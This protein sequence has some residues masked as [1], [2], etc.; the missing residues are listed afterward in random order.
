M[1]NKVMIIAEAGVNHNGDLA[2]AYKLIDVAAEAGADYVKFQTFKAENLVTKVAATADYQKKNTNSE[3]E[4]QYDMLKKLEISFEDHYKLRDYALAKRIGFFSTGF[5]LESLDFL[6]TLNMGMWKVPSGEITNLPYLEYI[7]KKKQPVILSTGM[8]DITEVADAVE[9]FIKAGLTLQ[10]LT[11]LHCNTEYPTPFED[12]NLR[13]MPVLGHRFGTNFGYSDHTLGI[14]V[15]IASVAMGATVIE[16]H[17]TLSRELSGPD[18]RSSLEPLEL[19]RMVQ[20]IRNI[21]IAL[22]HSLKQ[23]SSSE[24]KNRVVARKSIVARQAI[25]KGEM[26]TSYNL[27]TRRPGGGVS[28]MLWYSVIGTVAKQDY[29]EDDMITV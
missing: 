29:K 16:K 27:T 24:S 25:K 4:I 20:A 12:V 26:F 6:S 28:P 15:P 3:H 19:K 17:F 23:V 10:Q 1:K 21:E 7:A 22:G 18:H 5:D 9:V 14:E 2:N 11:I 13:A 8:A